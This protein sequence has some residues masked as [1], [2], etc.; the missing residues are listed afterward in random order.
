VLRLR[1]RSLSLDRVAVVGILNVTPDSFYDG[2]RYIAA[3]RALDRVHA[4]IAEGVDV[5]EVGGEKAGPGPSVS[6]EEEIARVV[7]VIEAIRR[8][9]DLPISIDSWKPDVA[10]AAVEAG[11]DIVNSI[12]GFDDPRLRRVAAETEAGVVVMHIQGKPRVANPNPRYADVVGDVRSSLLERV[13]RCLQDGVLPERIMID[14]GPGF[15]KTAAHDLEIVR[16]IDAFT[17]LPYPV[18][19][20]AS[21]KS[22]IG[23]VLGGGPDE[24]LEGTLAVLAWGV[25]KGVK[26]VRVHDVQA[27]V[28]TVKM[29]EAV[30]HPERVEA[31]L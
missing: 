30:L 5:I 22:F 8:E 31:A 7:P 14:P 13:E 17:A 19:L 9:T 26:L 23:A 6:A 25:L 2:G 27:A 11:A 1:T 3:A 4:M 12:D 15:G 29:T 18:M 28:R 24:R 10:R 16:R 20:A 21:R